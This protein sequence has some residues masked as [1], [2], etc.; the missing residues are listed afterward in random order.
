MPSLKG[1]NVRICSAR[2]LFSGG[3]SEGTSLVGWVHMFGP[4]PMVGPICRESME[5]HDFIPDLPVS[6]LL[7]TKLPVGNV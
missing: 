2:F 3:A 5:V 4:F 1:G 7:G 6:Y